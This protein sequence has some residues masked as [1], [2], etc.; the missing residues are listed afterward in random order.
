MNGKWHMTRDKWHKW[1]MMYLFDI[2]K[3]HVTQQ[4][5]IDV[6]SD[7]WLITSDTKYTRAYKSHM[8]YAQCVRY[9]R[10]TLHM[11]YVSHNKWQ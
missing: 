5:I 2:F 3:L 6:W 10:V 4:M 1:W 7:M 11:Q 9:I 8:T